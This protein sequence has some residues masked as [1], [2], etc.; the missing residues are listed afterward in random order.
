[1]GLQ[2]QKLKEVLL[3]R[4]RYRTSGWNPLHRC[5][6]GFFLGGGVIFY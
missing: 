5:L 1:M 4:L 3:R 2:V 6:G